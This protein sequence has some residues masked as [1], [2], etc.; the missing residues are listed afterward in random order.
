MKASILNRKLHR[1]GALLVA[2][3]LLVIICTGFLLQLKKDTDWVQPPTAT[4]DDPALVLSF[5]EILK[6]VRD[7]PAAQTAG[8]DSWAD[9]DR[10]DVRVDRGIVKVRG[11]NRW[12]VQVDTRS[13]E[14]LHV[15]FR[16][17]DFIESLHDGSWFHEKAKLWI[18]LPTAVIL[19]G[20]WGTGIYLWL[21][22]H[23]ARRKRV[24]R[25]R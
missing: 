17:S 16:R 21:L 18:F 7:D 20:L 2:V 8:I 3:P 22:P 23:L 4:S 25:N 9:V 1:W 10:L 5:D 15:A 6:H 12:E 24:K 14:V 13:G 19:L 11:K